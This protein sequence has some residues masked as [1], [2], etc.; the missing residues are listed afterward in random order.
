LNNGTL[1]D[2]NNNNLEKDDKNKFRKSQSGENG[3]LAAIMKKTE[4]HILKNESFLLPPPL[5]YPG[6]TKT[7]QKNG[8]NT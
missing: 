6:N 5:D 2:N 4:S 3:L 8:G 7:N 1:V